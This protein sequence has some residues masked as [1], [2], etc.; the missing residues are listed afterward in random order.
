MSN[1]YLK[2]LEI[3]VGQAGLDKLANRKV[4]ICGVGGVGSF[5]AEALARSGIGELVLVDFD[6]VEA[7]NLNRQLMSDKAHI[8][9]NKTQV[10]KNRLELISDVKISTIDT[11][12]DENFI[13]PNGLDYVV[14]CIDTLTSKMTL[15]K[16]CHRAKIPV[17]SSLGTARRLS[18]ENI[19]YTTLD[20]TRNDPLAKAFRNLAKKE[21]YNHKIEVVYI[22]SPAIESKVD[23]L[24]EAKNRPTLGSSIFAVG[25]AGLYIAYIVCSKLLGGTMKFKDFKYERIAYEEIATK[26]GEMLDRLEKAQD[27]KE[28][29]AVFNEINDY[30]G[31]LQT[32]QTLCSIRYTVNT[33]DEFYAAE[34]D[35]WDET[36]PKIAAFETRYAKICLDYPRREELGIPET[37]FKLNE[38]AIK[39]FD[40]CIIE[41]L[42]VENRL[43]SEYS[44]LKS[45]AKIE[46]DGEV[47]NLTNIEPMVNNQDRDIRRRAYA[48]VNEFYEKNEAE[49]DRIYDELVKV[50]DTM[51]KKLGYKDYIELGYLRMFRLDYNADMVANYRRQI[52]EDVTPLASRC[53]EKQAARLGLDKLKGYDINFHFNSGNPKPHGTADELVASARKMYHEMSED[54][55]KFFD[56]MCDQELFD[57]LA[58]PNKDTGGYCTFL[59][60]QGV[61]FI[62]ANF[63]GT[64]GDVDVLT[65]EAGHAFQSY[66]TTHYN[67]NLPVD[68]IYPTMEACEIHSMSMEFFAHPWMESFFKEDAT[69]YIYQHIAD[70]LTF[71]PYGVLVD[72]FQHEVYAHPEM[73]PADRK[74]TFRRLEKLYIP[75]RDYE[76][77]GVLERGGYFYRQGH[78]FASPFYYIDYTLAQ[79]CALQ[80]YSR[81]LEKDP[82][83][84]HDYINLCKLG[85]TKSFLKL[86]EAANLKSPFEDGCLKNVVKNMEVELDKIDDKVL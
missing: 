18:P 27:T 15:V 43:V 42:Q 26:Y 76:G 10:L 4:M 44:K 49:F 40:E 58:K 71:L 52:L 86:V 8:G 13:L 21:H 82:E 57:L 83:A 73:S 75:E 74:A 51:A 12:I 70:A 1:D 3:L 33:A 53:Y 11:F 19:K 67:E 47:Y 2:R 55:G 79:V 46:F 60:D 37:F 20:K 36:S 16:K 80:F 24:N 6:V 17:L 64:S 78:I 38:M 68:L 7:S 65:H 35:Y 14:D 9:Q 72:H 39:A 59:P 69:K 41:D 61:P 29:K 28:F 23:I 22:D 54:T 25:S 85:G 5:V 32:M 48:A 34:Q 31:H 84:W 63:R 66:M 77:F 30:R 56:M 81:T 62:F 50:R 45:S